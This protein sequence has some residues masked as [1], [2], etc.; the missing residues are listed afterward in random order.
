M[1]N[2]AYVRSILAQ[3][4]LELASPL[5]RKSLLED[6]S[7]QAEYDLFADGVLRFTDSGFSIRRS[8]LF[9]AVRMVLSG[10]ATVEITDTDNQNWELKDISTEEELPW[11]VIS[12]EKQQFILPDLS[13]LSPDSVTRLRYLDEA[14]SDVNLPTSVRDSWGNIL[15]ERA[16]EDNE[17]DAFLSEFR[18]TPIEKARAISSEIAIGTIDIFSLV[19]HSRRYFERLI[20]KY[21]GSSS[22]RDYAAGSCKTLFNQLAMWRP[23]EGFLFSLLLSSHLSLTAEIGIDHMDKE[24]LIRAFNF[25]DKQGDRISQLGAIEVGLH[26]LPSLPEIKPILIHLIEQIYND[27]VDK[28]VS[29]FS[30]LSALFILVDGE[31]SRTRLLSTEPPFYRRLAALSQAGLIYRQIVNS[32]INIDQFVEW[33]MNSRKEQYYLQSLADM[34]LEPRWSPDYAVASQLKAEFAGR[35]MII[36]RNYEQ[37]I[38]DDEILDLVLTS[39]LKKFPSPSNLIRLYWPG[40][41]EGMDEPQTTLSEEIAEEIQTELAG[42]E[43]GPSSFIALVN[44]ALIFRVSID[45]AELAAKA[46]KLASYRLANVE[47]K[48]QLLAVLNGLATLAAVTRSSALADELRILVRIYR[49]DAQYALSIEEATR[50]CVVTSASRATLKDWRDF[51]GDWLTELAFSDLEDHEGKILHA[52]LQHLCHVVPELWVSCGRADAA[53]IAYNASH[54]SA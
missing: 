3:A 9:E 44:S 41:L 43:I 37:E 33:A 53:L 8:N 21:D 47:D 19:P 13:V 38:K 12:R 51:A 50:I 17:V 14:A 26:I 10:T 49:R 39:T 54:H 42:E 2:N 46:L 11:L 29:G 52:H 7:F 5:L 23:Y 48:S 4:A 27:D 16:L 35:L 22:I 25:L 24:D 18:D 1:T 15:R 20:G 28:P 36:V 30:L 31:L 40:P 6:P 32:A 34:R 45:Q